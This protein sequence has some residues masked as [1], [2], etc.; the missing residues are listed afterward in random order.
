MTAEK[1]VL[2][3]HEHVGVFD[4]S[5]RRASLRVSGSDRIGFLQNLLSNDVSALAI[6]QFQQNAL[7]DKKSHVLAMFHLFVGAEEVVLLGEPACI[8][9]LHEELDRLHFTE[10]VAFELQIEAFGCACL[11]GPQA[12]DMCATL[13]GAE[14]PDVGKG[15]HK[16]IAGSSVL[17][18]CD[19]WAGER[20][21][22]IC[23][24][25]SDVNSFV[26][27]CSGAADVRLFE[28]DVYDI[29][30]M[31]AGVPR[32]G[33]DVDER[34]MVMELD[35]QDELISFTKGCFPGQEIS[36]S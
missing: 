7:L 15:K 35:L 5:G 11:V 23:G 6:G 8:R 25:V 3:V 10:D 17:V 18:L 20:C 30:R 2:F 29:L 34:Y 13:L 1:D 32:Y 24:A 19:D 22:D 33:V 21:Y 9:R 12:R 36:P 28:E 31:E 27:E 14:P 16:G 4:L 26:A